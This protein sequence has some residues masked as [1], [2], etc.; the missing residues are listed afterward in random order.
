MNMIKKF[1]FLLFID[2]EMAY[3][4]ENLTRGRQIPADHTQSM[5]WLLMLWRSQEKGHQQPRH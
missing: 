1:A 2:T 4:V 5:P 3:V